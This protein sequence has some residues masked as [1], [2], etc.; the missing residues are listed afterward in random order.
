MSNYEIN[1]KDVEAGSIF[2]EAHIGDKNKEE[3]VEKGN[4]DFFRTSTSTSP[5]IGN[6]NNYKVNIKDSKITSAFDG[7]HLGDE[8]TRYVEKTGNVS[9][10][11]KD[12]NVH[13]K[14]EIEAARKNSDGTLKKVFK[15][16]KTIAGKIVN[17]FSS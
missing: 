14:E 2:K 3:V 1:L 5:N 6:D 8:N 10:G 11:M 4:K 13:N 7:V 17:L 12:I 15:A 16:I 9:V